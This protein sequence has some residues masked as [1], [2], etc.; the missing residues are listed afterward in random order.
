MSS[1]SQ[2]TTFVDL[3][4]DLQNRVRVTTGVAATETQ[5]KR[6][7]NIALQDMHTGFG[8]KFWWAERKSVL[9]TQPQY[10]IGTVSTTK[11]ST[12]ITGSSTLW[13]STNDF[14]VNNMR[15]GG[16]ISF[17]GND[18]YEISAV[19]SDTSATLTTAFISTAISGGSYTYFEDEYALSSDFLRPLDLQSFSD[20]M[21][22]ELISRTDFRRRF[23]RNNVTGRPQVATLIVK[24][25]S[26]DVNLRRRVRFYKPPSDAFLIP[27]S[28]V[29]NKLAVSATGT[30]AT[31]LSADTDEPIVP[32]AYRQAL[33]THALWHWYRDKK[34]DARSQEVAQEWAGM[35]ER[36]VA[37]TEVGV[38][39]RPRLQPNTGR[40]RSN[41]RNPWRGSTS[42]RYVTGTRFDEIR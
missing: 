20:A 23:P 41:A 35:M 5:A 18:V 22:I 26:G 32:L 9:R 34:D 1:T 17:G 28:F 40:Y 25:P 12:T 3:Y 29:T 33:V 31:A 13:N 39:P 10:A 36:I 8:E 11:G 24:S 21:E 15:I 30:E 42:G 14:S 16:K 2:P 38:T 4:T 27:Y 37:A 19:A 6:Y 7:I